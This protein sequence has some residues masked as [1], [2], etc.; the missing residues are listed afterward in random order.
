MKLE[1]STGFRAVSKVLVIVQIYFELTRKSPTHTTVLNW[2]HKI[3]Y[4]RLSQKKEIAN[5]W[6]IIPDES[7]QLGRDKA[8]VIYGI[9]EKNLPSHRALN[10][11]DLVP[12]R[13][14]VKTD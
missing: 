11:T 10:F 8:L 5:D 6:I 2:V 1:S 3:G 12:L 14:I 13:I 9:R 7:I 4:F